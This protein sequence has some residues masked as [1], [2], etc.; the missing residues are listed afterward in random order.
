M[1]DVQQGLD[2]AKKEDYFLVSILTTYEA[3]VILLFVAA[4]AVAKI[5][6]CLKFNH[7]IKLN[8]LVST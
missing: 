3:K 8:N 1:V 4:G 5:V 7:Q 6:L 2:L